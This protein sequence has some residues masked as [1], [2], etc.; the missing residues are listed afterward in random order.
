MDLEQ[1]VEQG[2]ASL[3]FTAPVVGPD[4]ERFLTQQGQS[5]RELAQQAVDEQVSHIY[6]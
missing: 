6:W 5:L 1:L 4:M 3:L 2:I